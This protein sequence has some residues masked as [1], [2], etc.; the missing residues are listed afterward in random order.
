ML[1]LPDP[2]EIFDLQSLDQPGTLIHGDLSLFFIL[3]QGMLAG[4]FPS[5]F[6]LR[7]EK[8][9]LNLFGLRSAGVY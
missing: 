6:H 7:I 5:S 8:E 2:T 3:R 1:G 9:P 4:G